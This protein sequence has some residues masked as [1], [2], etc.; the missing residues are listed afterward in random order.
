MASCTCMYS[1]AWSPLGYSKWP[2]RIAPVRRSRR[3]TS[4]WVGTR[5]MVSTLI[6]GCARDERRRRFLVS[7]LAGQDSRDGSQNNLPV[8]CERPVVDVLHV[9]LHPGL[10][11]QRIPTLHRPQACQARTHAQAPPLPGL[12]E[13]H[14]FGNRRAR[15]HQRHVA[16]EDVPQLRPFVDRKFAQEAAQAGEPWVV[17]DFERRGFMAQ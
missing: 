16:L 14:F 9:H 5:C 12:V 4:S 3:T 7:A 2:S 13:L 10:E 17:G 6:I 15:T 1:L 11:V 8:Q